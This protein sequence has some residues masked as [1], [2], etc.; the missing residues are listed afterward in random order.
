M[1]AAQA[2]STG[3]VEPGR[4]TGDV[5][6][7]GRRTRRRTSTQKSR[8]GRASRRAGSPERLR[9]RADQAEAR[10][11]KHQSEGASDKQPEIQPGETAGKREPQGSTRSGGGRQAEHSRRPRTRSIDSRVAENGERREAVGRRGPK[12]GNGGE[13]VQPCK[14]TARRAGG[15]TEH[16]TLTRPRGEYEHRAEYAPP[17]RTERLSSSGNRREDAAQTRAAYSGDGVS[18]DGTDRA[19]KR[20]ARPERVKQK[21]CHPTCRA[22]RPPTRGPE[23]GTAQPDGRG[24][25]RESEER[26]QRTNSRT[27][28]TESR[29][30][31]ESLRRQ[32]M[33]A[34]GVPAGTRAGDD[35]GEAE[36]RGTGTRTRRDNDQIQELEKDTDTTGGITTGRRL[37][38][39]RVLDSAPRASPLAF[40]SRAVPAVGRLLGTD[41]R[42]GHDKGAKDP[43]ETS[44]AAGKATRR[45]QG[46]AAGRRRNRTS[47]EHAAPT[48]P[49]DTRVPGIQTDEP[50]LTNTRARATA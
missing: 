47:G 7:R 39:G 5:E 15:A 36:S 38:R 18:N 20:Q 34:A 26:A 44:R 49:R 45:R 50:G 13:A 23:S 21:S 2:R 42:S 19:V 41:Q 32:R 22:Q 11:R 31:A 37:F 4:G 30:T 27:E 35:A 25:R 3:D 48:G 33:T 16:V 28:N 17:S 8:T 46:R 40:Q 14:R 29:A 6:P 43:Q 9:E 10:N 24:S 1:T 12:S